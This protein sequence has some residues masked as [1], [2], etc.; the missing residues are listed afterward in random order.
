MIEKKEF[1]DKN[2][3]LCEDNCKFI[4]Y[5]K[6]NKKIN[7]SCEI[8]TIMSM[9]REINK[10]K[11]LQNFKDIKKITNINVIKCFKN[12]FSKNNI[13]NNYGFYILCFIFA[14]FFICIILFC[15]KFFNLL[16]KEI[17]DV[18]EAL[19]KKFS[20]NK[21]NNIENNITQNKIKIT[22]GKKEKI[23]KIKS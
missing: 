17:I 19:K 7:C 21:E 11:L 8:K 14:L 22:K 9:I 20:E 5:D 16:I 18:S 15:F 13:K 6:I 2:M 12:V 3:T 4:N 10:E 1:I 23:K